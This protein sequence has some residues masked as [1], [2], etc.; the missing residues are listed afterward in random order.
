MG[1]TSV[2]SKELLRLW[3]RTLTLT[4]VV[5]KRV[6]ARLREEFDVTLPRFDVMAAL[7]EAPGGMNMGEVSRRL[8]VSNGNVTG[9][10]GRLEEEGLVHRRAKPGDRR[11]QIVQLTEAG[12]ETFEAMA[13]AH[14]AWISSM[15]STLTAEEV[16]TLDRLLKNAKNS[17]L[18][19]DK[20]E[21]K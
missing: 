9:I 14:S 11:T 13:A 1:E 6:R 3:L 10:M 18:E 8:M 2:S 4:N 16:E 17:V 21:E 7:H 19:S 15:F 12:R 5:E 20:L